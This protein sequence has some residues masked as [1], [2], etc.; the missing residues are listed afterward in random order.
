LFNF[1]AFQGTFVEGTDKNKNRNEQHINIE[2][3]LFDQKL[4]I[5]QQ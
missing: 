2:G 5:F 3:K 1:E 4:T